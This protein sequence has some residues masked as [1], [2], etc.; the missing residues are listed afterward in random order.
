[1]ADGGLIFQTKTHQ[2]NYR[3]DDGKDRDTLSWQ[4]VSFYICFQNKRLTASKNWVY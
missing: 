1:M 4:W 2:N 3:G